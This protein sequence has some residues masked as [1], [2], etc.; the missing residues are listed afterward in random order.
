MLLAIVSGAHAQISFKPP[1]TLPMPNS[2]TD[3]AVGD[4]NRDGILDIASST[5]IGQFPANPARNFI[6][7]G[8]GGG[9]FS[10]PTTLDP[11]GECW[12]AGQLKVADVNND[13]ILDVILAE[14]GSNQFCFGNKVSF[15]LGDGNGGFASPGIITSTGGS[16][17]SFAVG[18]FNEDG[19]LDLA[20][21]TGDEQ[22]IAILFGIG[23]G[24]FTPG[25][26]LGGGFPEN[27]VV[28]DLNG[29]GH[30]D[31]A[32]T[33]LTGVKV[34][35]GTGTGTFTGPIE[36][37]ITNPQP[38]GIA[39]GDFNED[40]IPDLAVSNGSNGAV[41]V[42]L[43]TGGGGFSSPIAF[44]AGTNPQSEIIIADFDGDGHQD[45]AV[46]NCGTG[47]VSVLRG[48]GTGSF[49]APLTFPAGSGDS[50][51]LAS[52]DLDGDGR[53]DL[54]ASSQL[55]LA[56]L[57]NNSESPKTPPVAVCHNVTVAAGPSCKANASIDGGSFDPQG[58]ALTLTQSPSNPYSLGLTPVTLT[59]TN[60]GGESARCNGQVTVADNTPPQIN[61]IS[62]SPNLIWPP[63]HKLIPISLAVNATDNCGAVSCKIV[64]VSSNES[65][66]AGDDWTITSDS[67]VI[68]R[69]ARLGDGDGRV[70]S[71]LVQCTDASHNV[72]MSNVS[73]TVP[74]D[75]GR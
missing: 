74:H 53:P 65:I 27:I 2:A 13:G 3:I 24:T 40:G 66:L 7:L 50:C 60:T 71:V 33:Y 15:Q 70:Y 37:P 30:L 31:L 43:G 4:F 61:S 36:Y 52:A 12:S 23:D 67:T 39:V 28:K 22:A 20:V 10:S 57:L 34:F 46:G 68:L 42:L 6:F 45:I 41:F 25:P 58:E 1:M 8:T 49:S 63:N 5:N 69:A 21:R 18:D 59:A 56:V 48:N 9:A 72:S 75:Q 32:A 44:A 54:V 11:G 14:G 16:L 55:G 64:S 47:N 38:F 73:V 62:A 19:K 35:F 26:I 17:L 51:R 29:D